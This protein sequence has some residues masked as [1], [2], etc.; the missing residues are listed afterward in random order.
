M[1][2]GHSVFL[3]SE[4]NGSGIFVGLVP[5]FRFNLLFCH[6]ERSRRACPKNKR[7]STLIGAKR[8]WPFVKSD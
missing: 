5:A 4:A 1:P 8:E 2:S 6:P 3:N 7:I